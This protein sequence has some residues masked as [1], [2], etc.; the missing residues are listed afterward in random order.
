MKKELIHK[1]VSVLLASVLLAVCNVILAQ[2]SVFL[3]GEP[4]PPDYHSE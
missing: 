4:D 3:W 1:K 2:G